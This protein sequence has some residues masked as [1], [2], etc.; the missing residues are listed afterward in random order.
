MSP[1]TPSGSCLEWQ[2]ITQVTGLSLY[3]CSLS[4]SPLSVLMHF[5]SKIKLTEQLRASDAIRIWVR[6]AF[7]VWSHLLPTVTLFSRMEMTLFQSFSSKTA[8]P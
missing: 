3:P 2:S 6:S 1:A 8:G 5:V 4:L 7:W